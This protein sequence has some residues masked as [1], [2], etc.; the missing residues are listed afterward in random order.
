MNAQELLLTALDQRYQK[1][2]DERKRC[3]EEFSEEAVHD[4]RIASRRLLALIDLL[5]MV[6]PQYHLQKLREIFKNQLDSLDALRDTQV[7]LAEFSENLETL[8][9]LLPLVKSLK[10]LERRLLRKAEQ[11]VR[12]FKSGALTR[13]IDTLRSHL[14]EA[15]A[16][17]GLAASLLAVVDD[18]RLIIS[19]RRERV[20]AAQPYTI[21]RVRIAFK[22]FRYMLEIIFPIV[23][24]FPESQFKAMHE[25]QAAMGEIQD[26]EVILQTL[27]DFAARHP[28]YDPGTVRQF[29]EQRHTE[30]INAYIEDMQEFES[31]WRETPAS[32]F[33]WEAQNKE[34]P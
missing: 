34:L 16:D 9:E 31:F 22:K 24:G 11:E 1:Y 5:R 28:K 29:Y 32:T 14:T 33:P 7:M 12:E 13:Q 15:G 20:D 17:E 8:P 21:H 6:S 30:S 26:V 2:I 10:K 27:A 25:Y 3:K 19:Q 23:P 4:L 18:S